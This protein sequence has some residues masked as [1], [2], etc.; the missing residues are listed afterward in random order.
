MDVYVLRHGK[1]GPPAGA[2]GDNGR[3]LTREGKKEIRGIA[4]AMQGQKFR[5]DAIATSPLPRAKETAA[6]VA[7]ALG[8]KDRVAVWDEL[9]PGGDADTVCY[10][11]AQY[12]ADASILICGHE[13]ALSSLVSRIVAGRDDASIVLTKGGLAKIRN[14]RFDHQPSGE[15][16]WLLTSKQLMAMR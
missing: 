8:Q 4:K 13:P 5:F 6:I 14:Y 12:D 15:L 7:R 9:A 10:R 2:A 11:A 3:T 1:A 16:Q